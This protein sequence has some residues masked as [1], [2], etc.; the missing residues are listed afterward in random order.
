MPA[1]L[2]RT[3]NAAI[4]NAASDPAFT[5]LLARSSTAPVKDS[6]EQFGGRIGN[7]LVL[8]ADFVPAVDATK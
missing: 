7:E 1:G 2:V 4:N 6:P 3:I 5:A 8:V